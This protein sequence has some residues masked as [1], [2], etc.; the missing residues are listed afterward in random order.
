M[1]NSLSEE[2]KL[3][4]RIRNESIAIKENIW[5][6]IYYRINENITA[7]ILTCE[8]WLNNQEVMPIH[9]AAKILAWAKDIKSAMSA[10]TSSSRDGSVLPQFQDE[11]PLNSIVQELIT[12]Q[13]GS[14]IYA[15]EL[16]LQDAIDPE[17]C[18]PVPLEVVKKIIA[19]AQ[20]IKGFLQRFR[21]TVQWKES[22]GRYRDLYD[23]FYDGLIMADLEGHILEV[24]QAT[25]NITGCT[26]EELTNLT[27][28]QLTPE[29]WKKSEKE[30]IDTLINQKADSVEYEKEYIKKDGTVFPISIKVWLIKD[31]EGNPLGMWRIV[32][33][34][35]E[36]K[37]AQREFEDEI[38]ASHTIIDNIGIGL[39]LSDKRGRF[40]IFNP[41]LQKIT[42]YSM[43]EINKQ[44]FGVLLYPNPE[45]RQKAIKRLREITAEKE[46]VDV[47]TKILTKDG[48]E[49]IISVST[50][51]IK[52]K[53]ND[54][55]LS[56]WRDIT[57]RKRLENALQDSETRFRRLFEASQDGIFLLDAG[58]GQ[59]TEVNPFL[60]YL[61]GYSREELLGKKLWEVGAFIDSDK[62]KTAFRELQ[63]K[64]YIRY[65]DLP[66]QTKDGRLINV[67]FVSNMYEVEQAR[68]IQCNIRDMT[69]QARAE[70]ELKKE[71]K[72]SENIINTTQAIVLVLDTKGRI[73]TFNPYMEEISGYELEEVKG[74]DWFEVF[75]P[76]E[77]REKTREVFLSAINDIQTKGNINA[78]ITKDGREIWIAWFDKTIKD[79][80]GNIEG[81]L[82]T[83]V[84]V[85]ESR[86]SEA[87]RDKFNKKL[88]Q[89]A[90]KDSHTGLFNHR[91]L[92]EA[93]EIN[94]SRAE[95][96][97]ALLSVIMMDLDYFKSIN[98]VYG[99]MF[100]DLVLKQFAKVLTKTIRPY[101]IAI[102]YG[103]EEFII[104]S[105]DTG[106]GGALILAC[107]LL[108]KIQLHN[109]GNKK[110]SIK[111]KLSLAVATYPEDNVRNGMELVDLADHVLNKAKESG[112][113]RVYSSMDTKRA[114]ERITQPTDIHLLKEKISKLTKRANQSL[115]EETLA[116]AKTLELKDHY[117][118]EH[119]ERTVYYAMRISQELK[120]PHEK[121]ALVKQAAMLHDL[122]KVGISEHILQKKSKLNKKEFEEVK[123]HPQIGVDIIRPIHSLRPVIPALLYHHERWDGKGYPYGLKMQQIP[124]TARIITIADVYEALISDR[125]YRKAYS[126]EKAVTIIKK[127]S[128]T[129]FD[130]DVVN[131]FLKII[132]EEKGS[133]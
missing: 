21:D 56:I 118:G 124:L 58:T 63:S 106:R 113:N 52:Y 104:I 46:I 84:D 44:G 96:E 37:K 117:T 123:M 27:Y 25:I 9:E 35:T 100:G 60:I 80:D 87:Q 10:I 49:R 130:P 126:K 13:F 114:A 75:L 61:L 70:K 89:L 42:G 43:A 50:S 90:L 29:K 71:K 121:I 34:V 41:G 33:D 36:R 98:D 3:Y 62:C 28:Q 102:R 7:V 30:A 55:F 69:L 54:M 110:H 15:I 39:S 78:I 22:E 129:Q 127:G 14:D 103:G 112:G 48:S 81:L 125:P 38:L 32:R 8:R 59:I 94:F 116:F 51:L 131:S 128:G 31:K 64:G 109:F 40:E 122:G 12:Q 16:M 95:R 101:D 4:K 133:M 85:T 5:N 105:P 83:G 120:F 2:K 91:Y 132:K 108:D 57:E 72:F 26:K 107:R 6:F 93:L 82:S 99:H 45:D 47:E 23:S 88:E 86:R 76:K 68:V 11:I 17:N 79:A 77:I 97:S 119:V 24:N 66:L 115:I 92:E 19:H 20:E 74:K 53:G 65:L 73:V 67:E 111:L 18:V 1:A